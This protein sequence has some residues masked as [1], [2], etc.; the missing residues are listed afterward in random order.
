MPFCRSRSGT[1]KSSRAASAAD[2]TRCALALAGGTDD[3]DQPD[4][5]P[6]TGTWLAQ[7]RAAEA[8]LRRGGLG[9]R[10]RL[11]RCGRLRGRGASA[12]DVLLH[13]DAASIS[14][15]HDMIGRSVVHCENRR[16]YALSPWPRAQSGSSRS[17]C[18]FIND[19]VNV[20]TMH[21][22]MAGPDPLFPSSDWWAYTTIYGVPPQSL[23]PLQGVDPPA[24]G[25]SVEHLAHHPV[26]LRN[27]SGDA[28]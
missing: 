21:M 5:S 9:Q 2:A 27:G 4:A 1:L 28:S 10:T 6:A 17:Y 25:G 12:P 16:R 3:A 11:R 24:S 26:A 14:R 19:Q 23:A 8:V 13:Y 18:E 7:D 20:R 22:V 15:Q